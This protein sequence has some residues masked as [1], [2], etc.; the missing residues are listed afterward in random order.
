M[1][2]IGSSDN[3]DNQNI[4]PQLP[5]DEKAVLDEMLRG[6]EEKLYD[7]PVQT[8]SLNNTFYSMQPTLRKDSLEYVMNNDVKEPVVLI[9]TAQGYVIGDGNHRMVKA[10]MDGST[11]IQARVTTMAQLRKYRKKT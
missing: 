6:I 2:S 4:L 11:T 3:G 5:E 9:K 8:V 1:G 7:A 10:T